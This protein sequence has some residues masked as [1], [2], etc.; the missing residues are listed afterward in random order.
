MAWE[1]HVSGVGQL[2]SK[3]AQ[4]PSHVLGGSFPGGG[5]RMG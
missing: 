2:E 3:P 5:E 4:S 1:F